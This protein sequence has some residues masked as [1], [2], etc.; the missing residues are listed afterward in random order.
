LQ[1]LCQLEVSEVSAEE[2]LRLYY[3]LIEFDPESIAKFN[4]P[5]E[6]RPFAEQ[7]VYGVF[8]N[9][10]EIDDLLTSASEHWRLERM[11]VVD[12]NVLRIAVFEMLHCADIPP[13]VSINEAI[14][15]GKTFGSVES[16]AFINGVLDH[17]FA[18]LRKDGRISKGAEVQS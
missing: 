18:K 10:S 4:V 17:L 14:E 9:K 8:F 13:K 6:S 5:P 15:M 2:A 11:S 16:G 3:D 12:R 7:L 1:V